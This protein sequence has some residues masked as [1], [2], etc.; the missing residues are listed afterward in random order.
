MFEGKISDPFEILF[1]SIAISIIPM[2]LSIG[3]SYLK[4]SIILSLLKSSIGSNGLPS[5][6]I[7]AFFS[8]ILTIHI[9]NPVST[10]VLNNYKEE[11]LDFKE[12]IKAKKTEKI[13]KVISPWVDFLKYNSISYF[14]KKEKDYENLAINLINFSLTEMIEAFKIAIKFMLLFLIVDLG[15]AIML[16]S[17]GMYMVSPVLIALPL[18]LILFLSTELWS[19][20][21][22][23]IIN[24]YVY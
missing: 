2:I 7:I 3:S 24:S 12:L 13:F 10:K 15:V 20:F 5:N 9:M 19:V 16:T 14:P 18:K 4:I 21:S 6:L 1:L 8:I 11:K 23:N 17:L 22:L